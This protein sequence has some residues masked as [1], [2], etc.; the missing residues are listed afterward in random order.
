MTA[1]VQQTGSPFIVL[2]ARARRVRYEGELASVDLWDT[3][4][5]VSTAPA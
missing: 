5:S 1:A 3:L 2:R 4:A